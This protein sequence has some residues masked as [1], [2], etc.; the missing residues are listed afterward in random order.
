MGHTL[1]A[2]KSYVRRRFEEMLRVAEV[3][4]RLGLKEGTVRLWLSR[5]KLAYVKL[6]RAV[7]IPEAE[8]ER[9]IKE[10]LIPA[11]EHHR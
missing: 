10:N 2:V 8:V 6:G 5:R 7:R 11:R 3:A 4:R 1:S 9:L